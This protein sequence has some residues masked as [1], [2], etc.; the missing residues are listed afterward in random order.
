MGI[1]SS[2]NLFAAKSW[3]DYNKYGEEKGPAEK[4]KN[5]SQ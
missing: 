1:P 4:L 3:E 5:I 2:L